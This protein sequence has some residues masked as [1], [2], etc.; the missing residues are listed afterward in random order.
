MPF[1]FRK[2]GENSGD[3]PRRIGNDFLFQE[4]ARDNIEALKKHNVKKIV[5]IDPHAFNTFKNE[6]TEFGLEDVEVYHHTQLLDQW[7]KEGKLKPTK[8]VNEVIAYH[9][10]CYLGRYNGIYDQ[11][12]NILKSIPGVKVVEAARNRENAMCSGAGGGLMWME[13]DTGT[14][15][16][17]ARTEQILEVN[18]TMISSGCPYCL[19]MISD[20]TKAK[21]VED[22]VSTLDSVEI[23][24]KSL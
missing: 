22:R 13:E 23:L 18:P 9:D 17:V 4:P 5:T 21:E 12:R 11:P 10:S 1:Y 7:I 2:Q 8:E 6:Y 20:G 14:R 3:T 19:T 24:E 15:I 16:N